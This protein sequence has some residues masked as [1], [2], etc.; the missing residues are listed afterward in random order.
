MSAP[1]ASVPLL[2][3]DRVA[4]TLWTLRPGTSTGMHE[5]AFDYAVIP[6]T[7]GS[8]IVSGSDGATTTVQLIPR[9]PY[10]RN[11]GAV[12]EVACNNDETIEFV[13]IE[14]LWENRSASAS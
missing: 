12:H 8:L 9:K 10:F 7:A 2:R 11:A 14:L 1:A 6:L 5:H 13:E 3:N 4:I